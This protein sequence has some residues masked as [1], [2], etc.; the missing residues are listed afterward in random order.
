MGNI[1]IGHKN[2]KKPAGPGYFI[3]L[4]VEHDFLVRAAH[5][6]GSPEVADSYKIISCANYALVDDHW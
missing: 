6:A 3:R 4:Y 1:C 2:T 5:G